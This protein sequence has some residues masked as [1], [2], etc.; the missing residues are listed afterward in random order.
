MKNKLNHLTFSVSVLP[1]IFT[2]SDIFKLLSIE[3]GIRYGIILVANKSL[4]MPNFGFVNA[5]L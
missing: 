3:I 2:C 5:I 4:V 1:K